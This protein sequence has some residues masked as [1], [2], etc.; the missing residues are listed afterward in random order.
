MAVARS[1]T[2]DSAIRYA[3]PVLWMALCFHTIATGIGI[4]SANKTSMAAWSLNIVSN[5]FDYIISNL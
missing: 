5:S 3:L 2:D 4:G 1:S